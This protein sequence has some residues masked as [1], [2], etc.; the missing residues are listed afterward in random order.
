MPSAKAFFA[1]LFICASAGGA[2]AAAA[3]AADQTFQA[4]EAGNPLHVLNGKTYWEMFAVCFASA[5]A[6]LGKAAQEQNETQQREMGEL[7]TAVLDRGIARLSTDRA[8]FEGEAEEVFL[9]R[10]AEFMPAANFADACRA[11]IKDHDS[12][13]GPPK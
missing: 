5:D 3:V 9:A 1:A 10:A 6:A 13:F 2:W 4:P 8:V 7:A 11:Y 12:H